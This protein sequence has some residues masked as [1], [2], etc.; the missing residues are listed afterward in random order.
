MFGEFATPPRVF[1]HCVLGLPRLLATLSSE[2]RGDV[3]HNKNGKK[4]KNKKGSGWQLLRRME[5][6]GATDK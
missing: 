4:K 2:A 1:H 6:R 3:D 5:A